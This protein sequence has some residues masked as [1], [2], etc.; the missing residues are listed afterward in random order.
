MRTGRHRVSSGA[1][2]VRPAGRPVLSG[3]F[4]TFPS[5]L[6]VLGCVR[7]IQVLPGG[8]R[9]HSVA[10]GQF[11]CALLVVGCVGSIPVRPGGRSVAFG[12]FPCA[13][14]VL[15]CDRSVLV[16]PGG[17]RVDW[18]AFG[19]FPGDMGVVWFVRVPSVYSRASGVSSGSF[20]CFRF[21]PVRP[22]CHR[23]RSGAFGPFPCAWVSFRYVRSIPVRLVF[24]LVC[25]LA[26]WVSWGSFGCVWFIRMRP[27]V[28][29]VS[30]C[31]FGPF[32]CALGVV[33]FVQVRSVHSRTP[34]GL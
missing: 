5:T 25:S 11:P 16:R 17:C 20:V 22:G 12:L 13:L 27:L 28:G 26:P 18:C 24:V 15:L 10:F 4:G 33:G 9:L 7:S 3:A 34:W 19:P 14:R 2:P 31:A 29:R 30:S 6:W 32:P 1:F 23:V 21:I 8:R